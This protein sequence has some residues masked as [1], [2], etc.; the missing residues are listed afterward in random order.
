MNQTA[1]GLFNAT[2]LSIPVWLGIA[3]A[4]SLIL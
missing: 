2:V 1:I 3:Y 4:I